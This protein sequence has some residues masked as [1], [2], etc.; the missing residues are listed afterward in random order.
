MGSACPNRNVEVYY[1]DECGE[2]I[3]GEVYEVDGED[4]CE[5]CL[6]A[7]FRKEY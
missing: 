3:E 6:H 1:C 7:R 5:H 4:L 2:E